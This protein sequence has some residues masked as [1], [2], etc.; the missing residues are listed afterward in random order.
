M[1]NLTINPIATTN[2]QPGSGQVNSAKGTGFSE[3][4]KESIGA[5]NDQISESKNLTD[6]L[7]SGQHSNIHETMIAMEKSSIAVKLMTKV[8]SKVIDAYKEVMRLQ[9]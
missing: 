9:L 7:V 3:I 1:S 6:G 8:Q 4:F 5:V 2:V